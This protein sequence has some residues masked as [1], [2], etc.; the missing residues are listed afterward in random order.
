ML[1]ERIVDPDEQTESVQ[2]MLRFFDR[3]ELSFCLA[4]DREAER[5][6]IKDLQDTIWNC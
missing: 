2:Q 6:D 3:I 4:W 1:R 5:G